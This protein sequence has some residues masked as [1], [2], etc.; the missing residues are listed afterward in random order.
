VGHSGWRIVCHEELRTPTVSKEQLGKMNFTSLSSTLAGDG[1]IFYEPLQNSQNIPNQKEFLFIMRFFEDRKVPLAENVSIPEPPSYRTE[2]DKVRLMCA[3]KKLASFK[4]EF[5]DAS[6]KLVYFLAVDPSKTN[7]IEIKE[8]TSPIST[9]HR[10][11]CGEEFGGIGV[12]IAIEDSAVKIAEVI[13]NTPAVKAG[14]KANDIITHV[15]NQPIG[16]LTAEQVIQKM[17]GSANTTVI[18]KILRKGQDNPIELSVTREII[19]IKSTQERV[20][21]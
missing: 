10:I 16:G 20:L 4:N 3:E 1:D 6:N 19:Q 12:K 14:I 2:I 13:E 5:Y 11:F 17:R 15:D 9:L 7:W 21:K 18:L 8:G